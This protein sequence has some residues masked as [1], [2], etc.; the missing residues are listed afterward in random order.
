[1]KTDLSDICLQPRP[2]FRECLVNDG[3]FWTENNIFGIPTF[4]FKKKGHMV[5]AMKLGFVNGFLQGPK[6]RL[7]LES[8]IHSMMENLCFKKNWKNYLY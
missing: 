2:D 6:N 8:G 7:F 1:M 3:F 5:V 4:G